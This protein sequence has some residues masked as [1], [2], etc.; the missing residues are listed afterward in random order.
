MHS[1]GKKPVE[2]ALKGINELKQIPS[3][4]PSPNVVEHNQQYDKKLD[5]S[6]SGIV[7]FE[8]LSS[9]DDILVSEEACILSQPTNEW[10]EYI[11]NSTD[12]TLMPIL[13]C[14]TENEIEVMEIIEEERTSIQESNPIK[15][16][17][18]DIRALEYRPDRNITL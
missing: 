5:C 10:R 3:T 7:P 12:N 18:T 16:N 8:G 13:L 2:A 1:R 6:F 4:T 14:T 11:I 17:V 15:N 9:P